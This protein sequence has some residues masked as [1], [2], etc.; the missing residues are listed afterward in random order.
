MDGVKKH[1]CVIGVLDNPEGH[2]IKD[3]M[4]EWLQENYLIFEVLH[5]GSKF[6][7]TALK[8]AQKIALENKCSVLYLHTKGAFNKNKG[9][10]D[11]RNMWKYE[12]KAPELYFNQINCD[13]PTI[14][15]PFIGDDAQTWYNGF[16]ANYS[17]WKI[18]GD[19]EETNNRYYYE[20]L[21]R[22][23]KNKVRFIGNIKD[24]IVAGTITS[25]KEQIEM[26]KI[27][28]NKSY[29]YMNKAI[30]CHVYDE[31]I[32]Y[33]KIVPRLKNCKYVFDIYVT[34]TDNK[35]RTQDIKKIKEI[36]PNAF[37]DIIP[38][39]GEDVRGFVTSIETMFKNNKHYDYVLKIHTKS[40][41]QWREEL[42]DSLIVKDIEKQKEIFINSP[43]FISSQK[44]FKKYDK[45]QT[46][47]NIKY[48]DEQL[49]MINCEYKTTDHFSGTMFWIRFDLIEKYIYKKLLPD[50]F[51][52]SYTHFAPSK[53]HSAELLFGCI[54]YNEDIRNTLLVNVKEHKYNSTER[55]Q[56][57]KEK[58]QNS[59]PFLIDKRTQEQSI[60]LTQNKTN[61][62]YFS[63][64]NIYRIN[65]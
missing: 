36:F 65:N 29:V 61:N 24:N 45:F 50:Y 26:A 28:N 59:R 23:V 7:Y 16:V 41:E 27:V 19:I 21:F 48:L 15:A 60:K 44:H 34:L 52:Q 10:E 35:D 17:A 14:I 31:N 22:K 39:L 8:E 53:Q 54:A 38:N 43:T 47:Q 13:E 30:T 4:I 1:I 42:L 55:I 62:K 33:N 18:L 58:I 12:F 37:I 5:D 3:E 64:N 20:F 6:E 25:S 2:R 46:F 49:K 51:N 57:L 63:Y 40:E 56:I 9:Q 11:I 32:F